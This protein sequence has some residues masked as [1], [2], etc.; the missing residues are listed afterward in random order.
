MAGKAIHSAL[1]VLSFHKNIKKENPLS[2]GFVFNFLMFPFLVEPQ[3]VFYFF[4]SL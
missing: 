4:T 2:D 3:R 1:L